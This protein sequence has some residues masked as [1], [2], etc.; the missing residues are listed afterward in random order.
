MLIAF[1]IGIKN[2]EA[3]RLLNVRSA[4]SLLSVY[5]YKVQCL[6]VCLSVCLFVTD[7]LAVYPH[8]RYIL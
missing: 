5:V 1:Y 4:D 2:W 7:T 6:Y 8:T 3:P